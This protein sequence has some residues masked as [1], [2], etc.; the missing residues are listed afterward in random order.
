MFSEFK[1]GIKDTIPVGIIDLPKL[2]KK[3]SNNPQKNQIEQIRSQK[4]AGD[5]NYKVLKRLLTNITP[6]CMVKERKLTGDSLELNL[7]GLSQ[8]IYIDIDVEK[9]ANGFKQY[10]IDKYKD[11]I[12]MAC[13]SCSGG[14]ISVLF[15][16]SNK[17]DSNNFSSAWTYVKDNVLMEESDLID[18]RCKN[19]GRAMYIS[20]DA[21]VYY[22]YENEIEIPE[23]VLLNNT[24]EYKSQSIYQ[25]TYN[26]PSL[27]D[28]NI[29][30]SEALANINLKTQYTNSN[31]VVDFNPVPF[32]EVRFPRVITDGN[33]RRIFTGVIYTI[34]YLNPDAE[35]KYVYNILQTINNNFAK[36]RME[37][38][39]LKR[40][41]EFLFY[42]IEP[43]DLAEFRTRIK[44]VHF[45][46]SAIIGKEE[47]IQIANY[48]NATK[49][50]AESI[51]KIIAAK[52]ELIAN[53][54]NV[55]KTKVQEIS[56]LSYPTVLKYFDS[57]PID[58]M[59]VLN[60]IN[61]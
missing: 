39:E 32:T 49:R 22:N 8:Y 19:I 33:K 45:N 51:N 59:A 9:D 10:F 36:P 12:S 5:P 23:A 17:L 55:T 7:L 14:G 42:N 31:A 41:F 16:V 37:S 57:P 54:K 29:T 58:L 20:Y 52:N 40:L 53:G 21:E 28:K 46:P 11:R 35:A 38:S 30:F 48:L 3:I 13:I 24:T 43:E 2:V 61:L 18:H 1:N 27:I 34:K 4:A 6:N 26:K 44:S 56:K 47:K 15:K 60:E 25:Y 50:K